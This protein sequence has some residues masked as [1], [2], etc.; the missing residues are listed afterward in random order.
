MDNNIEENKNMKI[1]IW[2]MNLENNE[3]EE[4]NFEKEHNDNN[5][6]KQIIILGR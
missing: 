2:K 1:M 4:Y 5:K 3:M 6:D